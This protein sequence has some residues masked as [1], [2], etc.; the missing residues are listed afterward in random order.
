LVQEYVQ[1]DKVLI[2]IG[3]KRYLS[4]I[5]KPKRLYIVDYKVD[6]FVKKSHIVKK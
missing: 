4:L 5:L 1:Y 3:R 2:L 6:F